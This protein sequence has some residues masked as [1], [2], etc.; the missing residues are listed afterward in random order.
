MLALAVLLGSSSSQSPTLIGSP[1]FV[2]TFWFTDHTYKPHI[3]VL[4][5]GDIFFAYEGEIYIDYDIVLHRLDN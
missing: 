5:N 4:P 2:R 3:A 1:S